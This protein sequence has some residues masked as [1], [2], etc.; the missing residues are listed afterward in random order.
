MVLKQL[1]DQVF[2]QSKTQAGKTILDLASLAASLDM[3]ETAVRLEQT[4][5]RLAS[6]TFH[7]I[8]AGRFNTGK[9]TMMNALL[10]R[11]TR[12]VPELGVG[13]GPMPVG[14]LPCTAT[15]T[16]IHYAERPSVRAWGFD[17]SSEEWSLEKY[18][19]EG[20][21]RES[22]SETREFF[23]KI[24]EFEMGF[25][26]ELCQSG[27]TVIDSPGTDDIPE[28]TE[29]TRQ[30]IGKCDAAI[31]VYRSDVPAGE[32]ERKFVRE[33][34]TNSG[35]RFFTVVN[36]QDGRVV[37][38]RFK[39]FVW[40]RLVTDFGG[41][42]GAQDFAGRDIYFVDGKQAE[43]GKLLA[44]P[45]KIERSG[46]AA[47]ENKFGEFLVNERQRVHIDRFLKS[48]DGSAVT[49]EHQVRQRQSAL[50]ADSEQLRNALEAIQPQLA[51]IHRRHERLPEIFRRYRDQSRREI[52]A[53]FGIVTLH[54]RQ[55]LPDKLKAEKLPSD[56]G[57]AITHQK[58]LMAEAYAFCEQEIGDQVRAWC[59]ASSTEG[60]TAQRILQPCLESLFKEIQDEVAAIERQFDEIQYQ[61]TGWKLEQAADHRVISSKEQMW[62]AVV[63]L[64]LLRDFTTV[65]G[66][67]TGFR[68]VAFNL[69]VQVAAGIGLAI[70]SVPITWP[71][72]LGVVGFGML[73]GAAGGSIGLA[74][75]IKTKALE[76]V[77][78][79]LD[80]VGDNLCSKIEEETG[81]Y[82]DKLASQLSAEVLAIIEGKER[83]LR[84]IAENNRRSQSEKTKMLSSLDQSLRRVA[85][86][87][88]ELTVLNVS[89]QQSA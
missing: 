40:Q 76:D 66:L 32:D 30:A 61:V 56:G 17:G 43:E 23:R 79:R 57:I 7:I 21:V 88:Q 55:T 86:L 52:R 8:V 60:D 33:N 29:V 39:G 25:P 26:A 44:D 19:R 49:I 46:L 31:V 4:A 48:A 87:R 67:S 34:L 27:V 18:Q 81:A 36:L 58:E 71:I 63:G 73:T 82:F 84:T 22:E 12:P 85:A 72:V 64:L 9:S 3:K 70:F 62:S 77:L 42:G 50:Q 6:D 2:G 11:T 1:L 65:T 83:N 74:Q 89:L 10:G 47:F 41:A 28:R 45:Q 68:G 5:E 54:L 16:S 13:R 14:E 53:G 37:D 75:R 78:S 69:G 24:R 15:L 20:T 35:T 51:D 38:E 59:N 80:E